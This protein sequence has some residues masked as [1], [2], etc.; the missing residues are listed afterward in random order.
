MLRFSAD[1]QKLIAADAKG[2]V[3]QWLRGDGKWIG[4]RSFDMETSD[5]FYGASQHDDSLV[6]FPKTGSP[7]GAVK[8]WEIGEGRLWRSFP[9]PNSTIRSA[10]TRRQ[11]KMVGHRV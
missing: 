5:T 1:G 9:V 6:A 4:G 8:V 2:F 10:A 3:Q 11:S 7:Q